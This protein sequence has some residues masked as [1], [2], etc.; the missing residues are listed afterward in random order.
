MA[1]K[2]A[3]RQQRATLD[4]AGA[5]RRSTPAQKRRGTFF[6]D[7]IPDAGGAVRFYALEPEILTANRA[8]LQARGWSSAG[9]I[10][11]EAGGPLEARRLCAHLIQLSVRGAPGGR[12]GGLRFPGPA[13]LA[14]LLQLDD[15]RLQRLARKVVQHNKIFD[16]DELVEEDG[17]A[18]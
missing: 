12:P 7:E 9:D 11:L 10:V 14:R 5:R 17:A 8:R 16:G 3:A 13:G 2:A 1:K 15:A 4:G 6:E 18:Q